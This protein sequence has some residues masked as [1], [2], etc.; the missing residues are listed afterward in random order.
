MVILC[1]FFHLEVLAKP[2]SVLLGFPPKAV[3]FLGHGLGMGI[4]QRLATSGGMCPR[5]EPCGYTV[6]TNDQV[7]A[8]GPKEKSWA[9][10]HAHHSKQQPFQPN[11]SF[12]VPLS[13]SSS[14]LTF[15]LSLF[16]CSPYTVFPCHPLGLVM[17]LLPRWL[18]LARWLKSRLLCKPE[19]H[20]QEHGADIWVHTATWLSSQK[21]LD[22][23]STS[24]TD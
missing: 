14:L 20:Y 8:T 15:T 23:N 12:C 5:V 2:G 18:F 10:E 11:G 22:Q 7:Q 24:A 17:P 19:R 16:H 1:S 13:Q 3:L 6:S 21:E 9:W 4:F